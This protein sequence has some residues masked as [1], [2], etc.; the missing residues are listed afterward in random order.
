VAVV[1]ARLAVRVYL[2]R[3]TVEGLSNVPRSGALIIVSNHLS[4]ADPA[5]LLAKIPRRA[6]FFAMEPLFRLPIIGVVPRLLGALPV[7]Q[8]GRGIQLFRSSL[9]A[10]DQGLAV[11]IFP[12]G[13]ISKTGRLQ[14][15]FHGAALLAY[16]AG[17]AIVPVGISGSEEVTW[18][19]VLAR[20]FR[21]PK[22]TVRVGPPF[23]LP[24]AA[25]ERPVLA[26]TATGLVMERIAA[27]LPSA[28]TAATPTAGGEEETGR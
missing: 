27:L 22:I 17:C 1:V 11:V 16:H 10:L 24:P 2:P 28:Y 18:P 20:P 25:Q 21:G 7:R 15:G 5:I 14:T 6:V 4:Y 12:E 3:V 23:R 9:R 19:R 26:R 13:E 8:R